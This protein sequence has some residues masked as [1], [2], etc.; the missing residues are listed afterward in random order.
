MSNNF[1][2][3]F[4]LFLAWAGVIFPDD[5]NG[6]EYT[7]YSSVQISHAERLLN[8]LKLQPNDWILDLGCGDGK[9]TALLAEHVS[10]GHVVGIDPSDSMLEKAKSSFP[11]LCFL[12]GKAEDFS[13][14][15][16]FDHIIAIHVMHWIKDQR[17]ALKNIYNHLKPKGQI[18][19]ILAPSKEGLP[20][21]NA[22]QKTLQSYAQDFVGF[23]NPQQVFDI[24]TYRKLLVEAGFHIDALHYV[25]HESIHEG[26]LALQSWIQQWLPH[27]KY[28]SEPKKTAFFN[29]LMDRYPDPTH[30]GE[31]VLIIEATK[32]T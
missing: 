11:Y 29:E 9:V 24:E 23:E 28:L 10:K 13:I 20:F 1:R 25:Y 27:G 3:G 19:F 15:A 5:W 21:Y 17:T 30:W 18:H 22:L 2:I 16:R 32:P 26:R 14:E 8:G 31:Y 7:R 12:N 6:T 4:V